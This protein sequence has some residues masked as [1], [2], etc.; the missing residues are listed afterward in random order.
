MQATVVAVVG[1]GVLVWL[2]NQDEAPYTK[3]RRFMIINRGKKRRAKRSSVSFKCFLCNMHRR[4]TLDAVKP[5][6][7]HPSPKHQPRL[8]PVREMHNWRH[9]QGLPL[10]ISMH[11]LTM[12]AMEHSTPSSGYSS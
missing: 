5:L 6:G 8:R 4:G 11:E 3:R 7:I 12:C 2:T 10:P 1:G 9:Q